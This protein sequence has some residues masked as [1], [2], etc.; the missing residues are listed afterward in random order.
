MKL[1]ELKNIISRYTAAALLEKGGTRA[2][3]VERGARILGLY[4]NGVNLLWANP[5]LQLVL[6][7]GSWNVGG[8]RLWF[9][10][11]RAFF[12]EDPEKFEGWFC[13]ASLDPGSFRIT[14]AGPDRVVLEGVME[15]TDRFKGWR[16]HAKVRR[17]FKLAAPDRL[18]VRDAVLASYPGDF[19]LWALAQVEPGLRGAAVVPVK[20]GA[21]PVHYFGPIPAERLVVARDHV[22]FKIDG[23]R[24]CKL[25]V[26]PEDLPFEGSAAIA[27]VAEREGGVWALLLMRTHD[28]PRGQEECLDP[29]KAD[30]A[31]PKG[32]VQSYNSGPEAGP[33]RFGEIELHFRPAVEVGGR[34]V[35]VAEYEL[36]FEVG[37]REN[38][39]ERL[40]RE[41][42][43]SEVS[44]P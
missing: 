27:H 19:N 8:L 33:E 9:S 40:R 18:L 24:V 15:A 2:L 22:S 16:L 37:S 43:L 44:L 29:A 7:K 13:P 21:Q 11:E 14:Y 26:R 12:Y 23:A 32:C 36:V 39:M 35:S 1:E 28:A 34:R 4:V 31:G 25:G 6:E 20:V 30:P 41:T 42:G 17:E 3:V 10:P 5:D 38:I